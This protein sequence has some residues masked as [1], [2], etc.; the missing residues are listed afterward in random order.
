MTFKDLYRAERELLPLPS[1]LL[2]RAAV[3]ASPPV[4]A[5]HGLLS[6]RD[7][8]KQKISGCR[9]PRFCPVRIIFSKRFAHVPLAYTPA[10]GFQLILFTFHTCFLGKKGCHAFFSEISV[11]LSQKFLGHV[12]CIYVCASDFYSF[13]ADF[14]IYVCLYR[15]ER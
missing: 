1:V 11:T 4:E 12:L 5:P 13:T 2:M 8:E 15:A 9:T 6:C 10:T 7:L 3:C 14:V